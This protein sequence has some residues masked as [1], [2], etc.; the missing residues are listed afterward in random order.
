MGV[1]SLPQR[2]KI[3][4]RLQSDI[5][6]IARNKQ[7][8]HSLQTLITLFSTDEQYKLVTDSIK[9]T[10]LNLSQHP[11]A[12]HFLQK[13]ISL[14]PLKHT[15]N[16]IEIILNDFLSYALDKHGMCVIKQMIKKI[17][18]TQG[19]G[20]E[21]LAYEARK[22]IVHEVNFKIDQLISDPYGNYIIQFCYELFGEEK[23]GGIT[24]RIIDKILQFS[25]QKYSSAVI[26]KCIS[27]FW[28][29]KDNLNK[30]KNALTS[31]IIQE[32]YRNKESNKILLELCEKHDG[33]ALR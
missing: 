7:G 30:L 8:T 11:N 1:C 27:T 18:Q 31:D 3:V 6:G 25:L 10:F 5:P 13:I 29:S 9:T 22:R 12:T 23:C 26:F 4:Q 15:Y 24:E 17:S 21:G 16:F 28:L 14:F 33:S 32:M 19:N 20:K 2:I